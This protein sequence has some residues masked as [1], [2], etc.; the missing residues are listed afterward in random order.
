M[1]ATFAEE[2]SL[3]GPTQGIQLSRMHAKF[4]VKCRDTLQVSQL[5]K[6][7]AMNSVEQNAVVA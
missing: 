4:T 5:V 3:I 6:C 1:S 2:N 7:G